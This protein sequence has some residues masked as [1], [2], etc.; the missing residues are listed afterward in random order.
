VAAKKH[1]AMRESAHGEDRIAKPFAIA[2]RSAGLGRPM[3]RILAVRQVAPQNQHASGSK[4]LSQPN[5][6][7]CPAVRTRTVSKN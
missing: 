2:L 4:R 6:K 3:W 5:Q 7:V 1:P